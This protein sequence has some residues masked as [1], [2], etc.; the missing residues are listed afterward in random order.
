MYI[1]FFFSAS[2]IKHPLIHSFNYSFILCFLSDYYSISIYYYISIRTFSNCHIY[3]WYTDTHTHPHPLM[4]LFVPNSVYLLMSLYCRI[5][6]LKK[7]SNFICTPEKKSKCSKKRSTSCRENIQKQMR[8]QTN[9]KMSLNCCP[10]TP[11]LLSQSDISSSWATPTPPPTHRHQTKRPSLQ[12]SRRL[13]WHF[14]VKG[15][16]GTCVKVQTLKRRVV[17]VIRAKWAATLPVRWVVRLEFHF[18]KS[19]WTAEVGSIKVQ[20]LFW[21]DFTGICGSLATP[22]IGEK[23]LWLL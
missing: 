21:I 6:Q 5:A 19:R 11:P 22:Y 18:G 7:K 13:Y 3:N 2:V 8:L 20:I 15:T 14:I 17:N 10:V 16:D 12:G 23:K 9:H 1:S 4:L